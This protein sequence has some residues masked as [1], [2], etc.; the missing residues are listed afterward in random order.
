MAEEEKVILRNNVY[1]RFG[2][3]G[4]GAAKEIIKLDGYGIDD[5]LEGDII[6]LSSG[7]KNKLLLDFAK[8]SSS[9]INEV[10]K[11]VLSH[12]IMQKITDE[13]RIEV[14]SYAASEKNWALLGAL[15]TKPNANSG[16]NHFLEGISNKILK[17]QV[18]EKNI[19]PE[20]MEL[21]LQNKQFSNKMDNLIPKMPTFD[22][23]L[24]F[25]SVSP[26]VAQYIASQYIKKVDANFLK[27][28]K[29]TENP[30]KVKKI[31]DTIVEEINSGETG[32]KAFMSTSPVVAN[33]FYK[34]V[35]QIHNIIS[36]KKDTTNSSIQDVLNLFSELEGKI[37]KNFINSTA[38]NTQVIKDLFK[39]IFSEGNL[40]NTELKASF[41][42][43]IE[44]LDEIKFGLVEKFIG[45]E[46]TKMVLNNIFSIN[47][48]T[49]LDL[50]KFVYDSYIEKG[51]S[52]ILGKIFSMG[53]DIGGAEGI[54]KIYLD[55]LEAGAP[56]LS[57]I[58]G[59]LSKSKYIEELSKDDE[60]K[61]GIETKIELKKGSSIKYLALLRN[62]KENLPKGLLSEE[63]N[64]IL[65]TLFKTK[66]NDDSVEEESRELV[67]PSF[68]YKAAY[69]Y[70]FSP[71]ANWFK[72]FNNALSEC[73]KE[74]LTECQRQLSNLEKKESGWKG[75][76]DLAIR[77][78][79]L[80]NKFVVKELQLKINALSGNQCFDEIQPG[81]SE[82]FPKFGVG[83]LGSGLFF[84]QAIAGQGVGTIAAVAAAAA[85]GKVVI[86]GGVVVVVEFFYCYKA[87][88]AT[89]NDRECTEEELNA[90]KLKKAE[91][92][93]AA[94]EAADKVEA[95]KVSKT[96]EGGQDTEVSGEDSLSTEN[97]A[98]TVQQ[99]EA[100]L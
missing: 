38:E 83:I 61:E 73:S 59:E 66:E 48:L 23:K 9:T 100:E 35:K 13:T 89:K 32:F 81:I 71:I 82:C 58:L 65:N 49:G 91:V 67:P 28:D 88:K 97:D 34:F 27:F 69:I 76:Q 55:L 3:T 39:N 8:S 5:L 33:I 93:K 94:A 6:E 60:F 1:K 41:Y 2:D 75:D 68:S 4:Y 29:N 10:I 62:I 7:E 51:E 63:A 57:A 40:K 37:L 85:A 86:V 31:I 90:A 30:E 45:K 74:D 18:L 95:E 87:L 44:S 47:G 22:F 98:Q 99:A 52:F 77:E 17:E 19:E 79:N 25:K 96:T 21:I 70:E 84:S 92:E 14:L 24:F 12:N 15:L 20:S 54:K 11:I 78:L 50:E 53:F 42:K 56:N 80:E 26:A 72:Q 46:D 16:I 43:F 36:E 64:D